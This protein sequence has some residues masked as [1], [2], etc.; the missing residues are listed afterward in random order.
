MTFGEDAQGQV[1][2]HCEHEGRT[3]RGVGVSTD[4][5]EASALAF[6]DVINRCENDRVQ[7]DSVAPAGADQ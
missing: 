1:T 2:V 6:L 4:V 7:S 5:I 3:V